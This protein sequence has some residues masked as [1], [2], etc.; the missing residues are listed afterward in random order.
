MKKY[1]EMSFYLGSFNHKNK[2]LTM[3][4]SGH[5]KWNEEDNQLYF[6]LNIKM[7]AFIHNMSL[8]E[9]LGFHFVISRLLSNNQN[10]LIYN[11]NNMEMEINIA[12][13]DIVFK[14]EK[15]QYNF[16][17]ENSTSMYSFIQTIFGFHNLSGSIINSFV[18][19]NILYNFE[20][21]THLI[22]DKMT[23]VIS[24]TSA[25]KEIV[26]ENNDT[27]ISEFDKE[28]DIAIENN[29][30][31]DTEILQ[32]IIDKVETK[33]TKETLFGFNSLSKFNEYVS[34]LI[35]E[36]N[37][38]NILKTSPFNMVY[39]PDEELLFYC[40]QYT[41]GLIKSKGILDKSLCAQPIIIGEKYKNIK[42]ISR[43]ISILFLSFIE[44]IMDPNFKEDVM[45]MLS[46]KVYMAPYFQYV[47]L[48]DENKLNEDLKNIYNEL[49][50][51]K[52]EW[53][54]MWDTIKGMKIKIDAN[55]DSLTDDIKIKNML[56]GMCKN[57][58]FNL[59]DYDKNLNFIV[60][61]KN[62]E[63]NLKNNS[64]VMMDKDISEFLSIN[65]NER[66]KEVIKDMIENKLNVNDSLKN[67]KI[68]IDELGLFSTQSLKYLYLF[69]KDNYKKWTSD[70]YFVK[71]KL[72]DLDELSFSDILTKFLPF[73]N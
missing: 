42:F 31:F 43:E 30:K 27:E 49:K 32:P 16:T 44:S 29:T 38:P 46:Y 68:T 53:N 52:V 57:N 72:K 2:K 7:G 12:T 69:D 1:D 36:D 67:K 34:N 10:P 21:Q 73:L 58:G 28:L 63:I 18:L 8:T 50:I 37:Y 39:A 11:S 26:Q 70:L 33:I 20:N 47:F 17:F 9:T 25:N 13:G 40:L 64:E 66:F 4:L 41:R 3:S 14:S 5:G 23:S 45:L 24:N 55:K 35:M 22:T 56:S 19:S 60:N 65:N 15:G 6:Y 48:I 51:W 71:T 59:I 62:F 61:V 54:K